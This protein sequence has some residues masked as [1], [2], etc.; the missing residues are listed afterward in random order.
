MIGR[1]ESARDV[2]ERLYGGS[3]VV[4]VLLVPALHLDNPR[5]AKVL[6]SMNCA[7]SFAS[8]W[9]WEWKRM[10]RLASNNSRKAATTWKEQQFQFASPLLFLER[11][12]QLWHRIPLW[13]LRKNKPGMK[14]TPYRRGWNLEFNGLGST[15]RERSPIAICWLLERLAVAK[16]GFSRNSFSLWCHTSGQGQ[17]ARL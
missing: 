15:C 16:Q 6:A 3:A 14:L 7:R 5:P 12:S 11:Q 1:D 9:E 2:C 17:A 8:C 4:K 10:K 13:L